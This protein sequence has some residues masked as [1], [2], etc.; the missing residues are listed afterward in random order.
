MTISASESKKIGLNLVPKKI[1]A[2]GFLYCLNLHPRGRLLKIWQPDMFERN[3][4]LMRPAK[5]KFSILVSRAGEQ[6]DSILKK[7]ENLKTDSK[8]SHVLMRI[9]QLKLVFFYF[10]NNSSRNV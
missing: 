9:N 10:E 6:R 2:T 3:M 4:T 7:Q 1:Q 5:K 8:L